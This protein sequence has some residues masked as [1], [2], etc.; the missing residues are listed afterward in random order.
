MSDSMNQGPLIIKLSGGV[1]DSPDKLKE[2]C[3]AIAHLHHT[4]PQ[5]IVIVHGGGAAVDQQLER[6]GLESERTD[7]IRITPKEHIQ[8]IVGVLAG[9]VNKKLVGQLQLCGANAVGLCLGDGS[10]AKTTKIAYIDKDLGCVGE[11][12][13]GNPLLIETLLNAGFLPVLASIGLDENGQFLNVNAD[14]AAAGIA[15]VINACGLVFLTDTQGVLDTH[16]NT[17]T[18]LCPSEI[19]NKIQTGEIKGGMA[20]KVRSAAIASATTNMPVTIASFNDS[21]A[22]KT[23]GTNYLI[24][25]QIMPSPTAT[26]SNVQDI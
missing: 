2:L 6:L 26:N 12:S 4:L 17:I 11:V 13:G 24:G 21:D 16:G 9:R 8:E 15:N 5:G 19:E 22:L 18:N 10:L 25:T 3:K 1:I 14:T 7:G 23:L 20:A